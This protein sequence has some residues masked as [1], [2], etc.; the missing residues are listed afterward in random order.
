M[1]K[2]MGE[3]LPSAYRRRLEGFRHGPGVFK[4]DYALDGPIPWAADGVGQAATVHLGGTFGEI[5][6]AEQ[7]I[8]RGKLAEKPYVLLAQ[9]SPFD[10]S[11]APDGKHTAW[12][13]C[14]VPFGSS[15][16]A[17]SYIEDQIERFAPGF[18]KR[19]LMRHV[20][21]PANM[22]A[23]NPNYIGGDITGG[24]MDL[25]QMFTRP[26]ISTYRTP[27]KGI[28]LCSSSTPPGPGVH[29]MCGYNAAQAAL[30]D[31]KINPV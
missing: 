1:V 20:H 3:R 8:W 9:Q 21:S 5:A 6:A 28:Y 17:T 29:G 11:R 7:A 26:T 25:G 24:A 15:V 30:K 27:V 16:D 23:Y 10:P 12:A 18:R 31:M 4:L 14:H 2:I 13:Y 19:I 22:E